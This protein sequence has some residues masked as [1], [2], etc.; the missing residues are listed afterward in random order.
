MH[1]RGRGSFLTVVV[2]LLHARAVERKAP[3][4]VPKEETGYEGG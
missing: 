2:L 4:P 1:V 3:Y